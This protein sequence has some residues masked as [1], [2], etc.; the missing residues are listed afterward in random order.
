M[1][2]Q[3][4]RFRVHNQ[5]RSRIIFLGLNLPDGINCHW[6]LPPDCSRYTAPVVRPLPLMLY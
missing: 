6:D 2:W 3:P 1:S 4:V 5:L